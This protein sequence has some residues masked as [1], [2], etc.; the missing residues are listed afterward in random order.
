MKRKS[1]LV[2]LVI[3]VLAATTFVGCS[4]QVA[5]PPM[6]TS[7]KSGYIT[8][9]GD[10]LT[11]QVFDG[12][13]FEIYVTYDNSS[14]PVLVPGTVYLGE[15]A[16]TDP[17]GKVATGNKVSALAGYDFNQEPVYAL[18]EITAYNITTLDVS[19]RDTSKTYAASAGS[20]DVPETD[21]KVVA[22]YLKDGNDTTM[23]LNA[24]EFV[25]T[26]KGVYIPYGE[27][28]G[29]AVVEIQSSVGAAAGVKVIA[30]LEVNAS[31]EIDEPVTEF[32]SVYSIAL[33]TSAA[34]NIPAL[35]YE[36]DEMPV[37]SFEDVQIKVNVPSEK[38]PQELTIAPSNIRLFYVD[39]T[40]GL[41]INETTLNANTSDDTKLTVGVEYN[42]IKTIQSSSS[43]AEMTVKT[44][45]L[46]IKPLRSFDA[47]YVRGGALPA[48]SAD[49]FDIILQLGS[50]DHKYQAVENTDAVEFGYYTK[51]DGTGEITDGLVP[52]SGDLYIGASYM[53][54]TGYYQ[55]ADIADAATVSYEE[56]G[57]TVT[58][59]ATFAKPAKQYYDDINDVINALSADDLEI[60]LT[61]DAESVTIDPANL[62]LYYSTAEAAAPEAN[63]EGL[64]DAKLLSDSDYVD[65]KYGNKALVG[66][67]AKLYIVA[68]YPVVDEE[69]NTTVYF[70]NTEV[71]DLLDGV[72][73]DFEITVVYPECDT[74]VA[75]L[76][77]NYDIRTRNDAGY[78]AV[79]VES[80]ADAIEATNTETEVRTKT[81][82]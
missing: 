23:E 64:Q 40:T 44:A 18:G 61:V 57:L 81:W 65:A 25:V 5:F 78:V 75:G 31:T 16:T 69:G 36:A 35:D 45:T 47:S 34:G 74:L 13:K 49:D 53:G 72:A 22:H 43:T 14:T 32:T 80:D 33:R 39:K 41:E 4:D 10:F 46:Q 68:E 76:D 54:T 55:I 70:T 42:G 66:A 60:E 28:E 51:N 15:K 9:T 8:Q 11:N 1:I 30:R 17:D 27:T 50:S 77:L 71:T 48:V 58:V 73:D 7:V 59:P 79:D 82:T 12:S 52:E 62:K 56:T 37:P 26:S 24:S 6:P 21:V 38:D 63:E 19:L 2:S 29:T 20:V 3:A 67:S